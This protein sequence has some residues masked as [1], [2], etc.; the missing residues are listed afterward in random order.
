MNLPIPSAD[1]LRILETTRP[2]VLTARHVRFDPGAIE[3]V[4][5][6]LRDIAPAA[7]EWGVDLHFSDGSWRTAGWVFALDALNFCFWS[8]DPGRR[9]RVEYAGQVHDGYWA[10][11]AA[12]RR[13]VDEGFPL[14]DAGFLASL[15]L[16]HVAHILR[17][18]Q[19]EEPLIPLLEARH[20]NLVE[21]GDGLLRFAAAHRRPFP[22]ARPVETLVAFAN[23]SAARLVEQLATWLPSFNDV[24]EYDGAEVR[25]FKR[26]QILAAD[27]SAAFGNAG[28]GAF[29]DLDALTAFADYK[30]PQVLRRFGLLV[31]ADPLAAA[32]DARTPIPAG[33]AEE[34]EIRAATVWACELIR[35]TL[36]ARGRQLAPFEIDWAL[37]QAGQS[38]SPDDRPYHRTLTTFY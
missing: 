35:Q 13:A 26:A 34:V 32:I 3:R 11:V 33:S 1:P 20:R 8:D 17:P 10:L 38:A 5:G 2:V 27:L 12:L 19:P 16:D 6:E 14:W 4:A 28:R 15:S 29:D 22:G 30:V 25:F 24:A 36:A 7:P 9:W 23:R 31:Y 37:W 21:L 18:A